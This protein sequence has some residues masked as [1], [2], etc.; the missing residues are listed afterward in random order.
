MVAHMLRFVL[1]LLFALAVAAR[2]EASPTQ[3]GNLIIDGV[4]ELPAAT[5]ERITST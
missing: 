5:A 2:A 3:T 4:P 1:P